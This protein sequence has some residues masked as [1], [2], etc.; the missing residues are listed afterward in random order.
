MDSSS[1][2]E[3]SFSILVI[4]Y[5]PIWEKLKLTLDAILDQSFKDYELLIVDDGSDDNL[6]RDIALYM[7]DRIVKNFLHIRNPIN[8]GTVKNILSGLENCKGKYVKCFGPG[9]YF[10]NS[11]SLE[12]VFAYLEENS[13][14]ACW[15]LVKSYINRSTGEKQFIYRAHPLDI[16][17]YRKYNV[18]RIVENLIFYSDSA[19][20]A[21]MFFNTQKWMRYLK[22]LEGHVRYAEDLSQILIAIEEEPIR[23][24]DEEIICYEVGEGISTSSNSTF[25]KLL[26]KDVENFYELIAAMYPNNKYIAKRNRIKKFYVIKNLYLRTICRFFVNPGMFFFLG[27][28]FIQRILHRHTKI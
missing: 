4:T 16:D 18:G 24:L 3:Y 12:T 5:N 20:G 22:M 1:S 10:V 21:S 11:D 14:D 15:G 19:H 25:R 8:Q 7:Q 13:I 9:D 23:L 17:A 2:K 26:E 28:A 6:E 27:R